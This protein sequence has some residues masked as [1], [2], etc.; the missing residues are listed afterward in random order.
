[1]LIAICLKYWLL[2][3]NYLNDELWEAYEYNSE[4]LIIFFNMIIII[5]IGNSKN[6][7]IDLG[8]LPRYTKTK[9][10]TSK[11]NTFKI[12][13]ACMYSSTIKQNITC[14]KN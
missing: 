6:N 2:H 11:R 1:M 5:S 8:R 14:L 13:N 10:G 12:K 3:C 7:L 9:V 4:E